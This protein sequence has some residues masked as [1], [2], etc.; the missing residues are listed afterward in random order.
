MWRKIRFS[1]RLYSISVVS[2]GVGLMFRQM[3]VIREATRFINIVFFL[4]RYPNNIECEWVIQAS[5]GN[6]MLITIEDLDIEESEHCNE[7]Y[8]EIRETNSIGKL[9]G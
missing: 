5:E 1:C 2:K 6:K 8:L 3:L 4:F 7:D 9:I